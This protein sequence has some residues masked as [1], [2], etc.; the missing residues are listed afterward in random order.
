[1]QRP[2]ILYLFLFSTLFMVFF[3]L[4][5]TFIE[6]TYAFGLLSVAIPPEIAAVLF[7]LSP[8]LLLAYP[9]GM[10]GNSGRWLALASGVVALLCWGALLFLDT[11]NKMIAG[12]VGSGAML[13]FFPAML[14]QKPDHQ[15]AFS[16]GGS[17]AFGVL[18]TAGLHQVDFGSAPLPGILQYALPAAVVLLGAVALLAWFREPLPPSRTP[19]TAPLPF[20]D[21]LSACLGLSSV[22]LLLYFAFTNPGVIARWS[23]ASYL[24]VVSLSSAVCAVF[25]LF[26]FAPERSHFSISH[27]LLLTWNGLFLL[28]LVGAILPYQIHFPPLPASYPLAETAPGPLGSAALILALLL[29]PALYVDAALLFNKLA[30]ERV[31]P[32]RLAWA[33]AIAAFYQLLGIFAHVFTT[34]YDYIPLV[35]PYFRDRFWLVCAV[36]CTVLFIALL[37]QRSGVS[38]QPGPGYLRWPLLSASALALL[39]IGVVAARSLPSIAQPEPGTL[40]VLTYNIQQGYSADGQKNFTGLLEVIRNCAPDILGLQET[41]MAR[42]AGGNSDIVRYLATNLHMDS[43][44]GPKTV[45]GTFGIALLSRYPLQNPRTYYLYSEG[46]QTAVIVA[47]IE[48]A[49]NPYTILVTHLGNG[50]PLVQQQEVLSLSSGKENVILMGDFNFKPGSEQY[51]QTTAQL[52]DAWLLARDQQVDAPGGDAAE[53]IDHIFLSPGLNLPEARFIPR[54]P[55][56]HPGLFIQVSQ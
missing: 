26:F 43:Y 2:P 31:S 39:V 5:T 38:F 24:G 52:A 25:L 9:R 47:E 48:A 19:A 13:L 50:G 4:L 41:D 20:L 23:G 8:L 3:Q 29:H 49:G 28:A 44:Y 15:K 21:I 32:A 12:G 18:A 36:P 14:A 16:L 40:R 6:S 1:M 17:L 10:R 33:T 34:V 42:V 55:S 54:G 22:M 46:E 7:L 45:T 30:A 35:G 53:R 11:R 27:P 51:R 37:W 56:D